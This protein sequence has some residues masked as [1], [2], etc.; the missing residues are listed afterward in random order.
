MKSQNGFFVK[1]L[2]SRQLLAVL[3][4]GLMIQGPVTFAAKKSPSEESSSSYFGGGSDDLDEEKPKPKKKTK[5]TKPKKKEK[6]LTLDDVED[7]PIADDV[8]E[9]EPKIKSPPNLR[10][11]PK[12]LKKKGEIVDVDDSASSLVDEDVTPD[13]QSRLQHAE[14]LE[15]Q[16]R[17]N[18]IIASLKPVLE[19]LPRSGL[20]L[21]ARAYGA[22]NNVL[23]EIRTLDLAKNKNPKDYVAITKLGQAYSKAK[24]GTEAIANLFEAKE[25]NP[26]YKV[27]FDA[28]LT[29]LQNQ[30]ETYEART[31]A[32][33]M[34][35]KFGDAR[36]HTILCR[37]LTKDA[38][39]D[40][41]VETCET[42]VKRDPA[43]PENHVNLAIAL[44]D[45]LEP[46]KA[47][48]AINAAADQFPGSEAVLSAQ[49]A[50]Y[51]DKKDFTHAE[52]SFKRAA[53]FG[54]KS[55]PAW[56]G[57]GRAAFEL[58]KYQESLN[59]FVKACQIDRHAVREFRE[60]A[61][62]LHKDKNNEWQYKFKDAL[63]RCNP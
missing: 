42:A 53:S 61:G 48:K 40:K 34:I 39:L 4:L 59:A 52:E 6:E 37:L 51:M 45:K 43:V 7:E 36:Y 3:V 24:K 22:T 17:W 41:A 38:Y 28:L 50:L 14:S 35:T 23:E 31:L 62:R 54:P 56:T 26:R 20:L 60:M 58:H 33:D 55:V 32:A 46:E 10:F 19:G 5:S 30:G 15:G 29:E 49:G 13:V 11:D 25:L 44:R 1:C 21:L 16:R 47:L 57:L 27:A 12:R 18:E 8:I 9:K 63:S 2:I